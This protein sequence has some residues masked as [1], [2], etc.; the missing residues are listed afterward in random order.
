[1][2]TTR[3]R[4]GTARLGRRTGA[5][6]V[7]A[8]ATTLLL[9]TTPAAGAAGASAPAA[10][11]C[12]R[13]DAQSVDAGR[14]LVQNNRWGTDAAQCVVA[15]DGGF[16]LQRADGAAPAGGPPKSYPSIVAGCHWG[17]CSTA[18]GLPV[19]ADR[20]GGART[21][22]TVQ[23][24]PGAWNVSYDL[25]F[26]S[27]PTSPGQADD[28]ELMLWLDR[29]GGVRPL[30]EPVGHLDAGG[31]GWTVWRGDAGW[32]VVTF[33]RDSRTSHADLV[34]AP[35]VVE[36][37]RLGALEPGSWLTSVQ[38]GFEPWSAGAG[39]AVKGFWFEPDPRG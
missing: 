4:T 26:S 21:G 9:G 39:L 23:R 6:V 17:R 5:P 10:P 18:P 22:V 12:G 19:R 1:M 14:Y 38:V 2:T 35:F 31:T 33:V 13:Y 25:W 28:A 15:H 24:S 8:L 7:A 16:L 37:V 29:R 27:T 34:L 11:L 20:V 32:D 30:G 3:P 36:A